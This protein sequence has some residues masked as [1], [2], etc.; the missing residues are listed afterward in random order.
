MQK[1]IKQIL[2]GLLF[3]V[4]L[5][6]SFYSLKVIFFQKGFSL[7]FLVLFLVSLLFSLAFLVFLN[8]SFPKKIIQQEKEIKDSALRF[9]F[10]A[11]GALSVFLWFGFTAYIVIAFAVFLISFL[12]SDFYQRRESATFLKFSFRKTSKIA[13]SFLFTAL[14]L[15]IAFLVFLSPKIIGGKLELPRPVFDAVFPQLEKIYSSQIP[16]FSGEMTVDEYL[17]LQ[18][19]TEGA[20]KG[21]P[22]ESVQIPKDLQGLENLLVSIQTGPLG[23]SFQQALQQGR[24]QLS[25]AFGVEIKG[26][27]KMKDVLY[28]MI[29][30][31]FSSNIQK[32]KQ[33]GTVILILVLFFFI[34]GIF[35]IIGILYFPLALLIFKIFKATG[36]FKTEKETVEREKITI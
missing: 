9:V 11:L 1:I 24:S 34:R 23:A 33:L 32:Y 13:Q 10:Y 27:E 26:D 28:Q 17:L 19:L 21:T 18:G 7:A 36:F 29:S 5:N 25:K 30:N 22:L 3:L 16:G 35:G 2:V 20:F 4:F 12:L 14:T 15:L 6:L 8:L 31:Q